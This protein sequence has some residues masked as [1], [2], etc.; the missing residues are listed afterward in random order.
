MA[1]AWDDCLRRRPPLSSDSFAS[2]RFDCLSPPFATSYGAVIALRS[3]DGVPCQAAG[4][5][6]LLLVGITRS[7]AEGLPRRAGGRRNQGEPVLARLLFRLEPRPRD[8]SG[9]GLPGYAATFSCRYGLI[10]QG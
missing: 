2:D 5:A 6:L 1:R 10:L 7:P 3:A 9:E 4:R 8:Q